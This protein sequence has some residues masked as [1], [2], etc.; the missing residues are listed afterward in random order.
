MFVMWEY[1]KFWLAAKYIGV[2]AADPNVMGTGV[3]FGMYL[4]AWDMYRLTLSSNKCGL[5]KLRI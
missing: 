1:G 2:L 5:Y 3:V 4:Y